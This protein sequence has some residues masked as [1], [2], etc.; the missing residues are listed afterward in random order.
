MAHFGKH[1]IDFERVVFS[2]SV[3]L[4]ESARSDWP[5]EVTFVS[6]FQMPPFTERATLKSHV[7][8]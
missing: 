4:L 3:G 1:L 2:V 7:G 6:S 8:F 5:T